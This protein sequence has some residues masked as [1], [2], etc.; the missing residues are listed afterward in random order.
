NEIFNARNFFDQ[1]S[2]APLYR[3]NDYGFTLGGPIFIPGHYNTKKDKTFFFFSE[4]VRQEKTPQEFNQAVPTLAER[5]GN[6]ADVCP[7]AEPG[8]NGL[9]GQQVFFK[10]AQLPDCPQKSASDQ[11]GDVLTFPGNQVPINPNAAAILGTGII[12]AP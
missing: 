2:R 10:R 8:Q 12:P 7:F 3:R 1:T 11:A 9:P 5:S 6:F 4:E